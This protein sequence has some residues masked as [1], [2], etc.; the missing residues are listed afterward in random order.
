MDQNES[1]SAS[2]ASS[3]LLGWNGSGWMKGDCNNLPQSFR[4]GLRAPTFLFTVWNI[5]LDWVR[6]LEGVYTSKCWLFDVETWCVITRKTFFFLFRLNVFLCTG[7]SG[8]V[9]YIVLGSHVLRC[10]TVLLSVSCKHLFLSVGW[11]FHRQSGFLYWKET[12]KS[13]PMRKSLAYNSFLLIVQ[14]VKHLLGSQSPSVVITHILW[15]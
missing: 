2:N 14:Y 7:Y 1:E 12:L 9:L 3:A 15:R 13:Q 4:E 8:G 10:F 5:V 6:Y 11:K